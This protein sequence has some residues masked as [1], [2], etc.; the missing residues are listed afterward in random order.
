MFF[1]VLA[2]QSGHLL[3]LYIRFLSKVVKRRVQASSPT[4]IERSISPE[5]AQRVTNLLNCQL[6]PKWP[7]PP[8]AAAVADEVRSALSLLASLCR[9]NRSGQTYVIDWARALLRRGADI[10]VLTPSLANGGGHN[11]PPILHWIGSKTTS[12]LGIQFL[13]QSG[14]D[15]DAVYGDF[16][17]LHMLASFKRAAVLRELSSTGWLDVINLERATPGYNSP[18]ALLEAVVATDPSDCEAEETLAVLRTQKRLWHRS[19]RP[20]IL[21]Q[22]AVHDALK[23]SAC[24]LILSFI[25]GGTSPAHAS[26]AGAAAAAW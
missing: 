20:A 6:S 11:W 17:A 15:L 9:P 7:P 26:A 21:A 19:I 16:T 25:D 24:E 22:L 10:N 14:A 2:A 12:S 23:P 4:A 8:Q 1:C 5:H 18:I 3:P 13:L